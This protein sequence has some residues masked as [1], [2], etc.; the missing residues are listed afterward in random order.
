MIT[1]KARLELDI[2]KA[3]ARRK[4]NYDRAQKYLDNQVAKD[5]TPYVPFRTGATKSS[6]VGD[7]SGKVTWNTPYVRYIYY[8]VGRKFNPVHHPQATAQ[9]FEKSKA[10]N[11]EKWVKGTEQAFLGG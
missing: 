8:A 5:T 6:V 7:G 11:K 4:S 9:W 2:P 3:V 10:V 1:G